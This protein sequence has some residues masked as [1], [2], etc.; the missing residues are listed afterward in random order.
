[1]YE[2]MKAWAFAASEHPNLRI[3]DTLVIT[4]VRLGKAGPG[5]GR[6]L[7]GGAGQGRAGQGRAGQGRAGQGRAG[8]N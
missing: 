5:R 6:A 4:L 2:K 1:L 8:L 7:Q 3:D